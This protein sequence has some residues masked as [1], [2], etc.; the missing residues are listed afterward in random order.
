M[1]YNMRIRNTA[2]PN[3]LRTSTTDGT[4]SKESAMSCPMGLIHHLGEFVS[5]TEG[6]GRPTAY[7]VAKDA[8]VST[9]TI[10]RLTGDPNAQISPQVLASLC[11][12]LNCQP[13]DLLSYEDDAD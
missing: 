4:I 11:K 8:G 3:P 2:M 6:D 13:G 5:A 9:N 7:R 10:Y 1:P 12:A